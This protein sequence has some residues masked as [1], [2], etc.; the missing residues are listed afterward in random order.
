MDDLVDDLVALCRVFGMTEREQICCGTVTVQQCVCLRTLLGGAMEARPLADQLGSSPSATTRLVDGL[1]K[2]GWAERRRDPD[3][4]RKVHIGLTGA[5]DA[6]ARRL[7]GMTAQVVQA[8]MAH[9]PAA[10]HAQVSESIRLV[11]SAVEA[12]RESIKGCCG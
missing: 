6:E 7:R 9:V 1:V 8:M 12:T 10:K 4:R 2:N 5:G 11:R 3:D